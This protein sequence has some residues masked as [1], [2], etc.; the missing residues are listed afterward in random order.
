MAMSLLVSGCSSSSKQNSLDKYKGQSA[1]QIFNAGVK[2]MLK[3]NYTAASK[4]F[5]ALDALYPFSEHT[6]QAQLD[7]I[8]SYYKARDVASTL[9]ACDRYIRLYPRS[10]HVDYA[11]YVRGITNMYQHRGVLEH[12]FP[13][14]PS[15][16]DLVGIESA[17]RDFDLILKT[18]PYSA[19]VADSVKRM[20]FIRNT[21]AQHQLSVAEQYYDRKAYVGAAN[22]ASGVVL[23]YE[24]TPAVPNAL[25]IMVRSYRKLG[26][27]D[28]ANKA[29][30][31]LEYNFPDSNYIKEARKG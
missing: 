2:Q 18:Y 27:N 10:K 4:D 9:A 7:I 19:Y 16:R 21:L 28:K 12:F 15:N 29:M 13:S 20:I 14:N 1:D 30:K 17:Y 22:R 23:N 24:Q 5:E 8:Y 31:I 3:G 11:Y 6:Q 26:L 25:V